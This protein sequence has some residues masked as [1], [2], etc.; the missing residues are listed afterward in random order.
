MNKEAISHPELKSD[1]HVEDC[2]IKHYTS[3][4]TDDAPEEWA[5]E[6]YDKDMNY[7][8]TYF[9]DR[10]SEWENDLK[11]LKGIK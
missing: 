9:Y 2:P 5:I 1:L 6:T 11:A 3:E 7:L 8:N 4:K 10:R